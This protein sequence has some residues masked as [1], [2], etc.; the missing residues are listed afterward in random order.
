MFL[1]KSDLKETQEVINNILLH[2]HGT[3]DWDW[4]RTSITNHRMRSIC[5]C[6]KK[7]IEQ[8]LQRFEEGK[9][10]EPNDNRSRIDKPRTQKD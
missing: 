9:V 7:Q 8:E 4:F 10:V 5:L 2:T 6:A 3:C 1:N